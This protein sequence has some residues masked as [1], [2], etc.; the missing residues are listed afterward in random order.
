[1]AGFAKSER[2]F[3]QPSAWFDQIAALLARELAP[4]SRK[5]RYCAS[6]D[7]DCHDRRG[8]GRELSRQQR[9]G[10]LHRVAAG[11]RGTN[12]VHPQG[13]CVPDRGSDRALCCGGDGGDVGGDAVAHASVHLR[14]DVVFDLLRSD[15]QA[16]CPDAAHPGG[17]HR[18]LLQRRVCVRPN[19]LGRV[20]HLRRQRDRLRHDPPVRQ[21]AVAR[22]RR[23]D[24]AGI[25]GSERRAGSFAAAR[26]FKFLPGSTKMR[27]DRRC[28]RRLRIF[29]RTWIF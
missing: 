10:H 21:L 25:A 19:R 28:R 1:M 5:L 2:R 9:A 11:G 3:A 24:P 15:S 13:M 12:D 17:M 22:P 23:R 18:Y 16:R 27:R 26:G 14:D 8:P 4:N 6:H 29:R 7:H 20:G